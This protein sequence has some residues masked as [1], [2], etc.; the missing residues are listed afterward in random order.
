MHVSIVG[1]FRPIISSTFAYI[2][3]LYLCVVIRMAM[4]FYFS[5]LPLVAALSPS[6]SPSSSSSPKAIFASSVHSGGNDGGP[7][8]VNPLR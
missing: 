7:H 6:R 4:D 1:L 2:Y 8:P 3:V 5:F